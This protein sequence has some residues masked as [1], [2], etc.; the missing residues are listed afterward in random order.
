MEVLCLWTRVPLSRR[1]ELREFL[2]EAIP[3]YERPGGIRVRLLEKAD[4]PEALCEIIEYD[5]HEVFV[6]DQ[7]RVENDP[8]MKQLIARWREIISGAP[9]VD[10]YVEGP[11]R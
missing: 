6:Q 10:H 2:H 3:V 1:A 8:E 11:A 4:D 5:S 7:W 9:I